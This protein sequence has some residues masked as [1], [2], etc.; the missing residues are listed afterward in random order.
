MTLLAKPWV[1]YF[2]TANSFLVNERI[3]SREIAF[4]F[5]TRFLADDVR[6]ISEGRHT[7]PSNIDSTDVA[8]SSILLLLEIKPTAP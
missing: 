8:I 2:K 6:K 4:S 3:C 5:F 1:K 7:L